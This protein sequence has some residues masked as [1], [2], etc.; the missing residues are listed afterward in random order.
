MNMPTSPIQQ[1]NSVNIV[2]KQGPLVISKCVILDTTWEGEGI[3]ALKLPSFEIQNAQWEIRYKGTSCYTHKEV[4]TDLIGCSGYIQGKK[5]LKKLR[6]KKDGEKIKYTFEQCINGIIQGETFVYQERG[7]ASQE[8]YND[9]WDI[10]EEN[11]CRMY[12]NAHPDDLPWMTYAGP[13]DREQNLFNRF[14][15]V[16]FVPSG[17]HLHVNAS[18]SDSYHELQLQLTLG[19]KDLEVLHCH[20]DFIRAPGHACFDNH[21]HCEKLVGSSLAKMTKRDLVQIF[22][23]AQGCYHVVDIMLDVYRKSRS[24]QGLNEWNPQ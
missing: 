8:S 21:V 7:F 5:E 20:L 9:Y 18:F 15:R 4:L 11:G 10:L 2:E 24:F 23:G 13:I 17:E 19:K 1:F 12:S 16:N 22:G 3:M 6:S 14:K